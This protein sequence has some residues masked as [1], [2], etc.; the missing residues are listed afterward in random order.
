[1]GRGYPVSSPLHG[2]SV[3]L[4]K[5]APAAAL[6]AHLQ[7]DVAEHH[8][9]AST[10][11][12]PHPWEQDSPDTPDRALHPFIAAALPEGGIPINYLV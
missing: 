6:G 11:K 7:A 5:G 1:M 2:S 4:A 12:E 8:Q 3:R 10:H 9:P